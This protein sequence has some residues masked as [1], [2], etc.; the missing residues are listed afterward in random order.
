[1][2]SGPA[3]RYSSPGVGG[4][5]RRLAGGLRFSSYLLGL[6]LWTG[7]GLLYGQG[8]P[9]ITSI[10]P[11]TVT[12]G[13]PT[14]TMTVTGSGY[15][16]S[17]VVRLNG[18][19]RPTIYKSSLQL[20][21]TIFAS[22]LVTATTLQV[23]VF[24]P[25][26]T[27]VG[28]FTSNSVPLTVSTLPPP[29]LTSSAP[30][31]VVQAASRIRLTLVGANFRPGATVV[32]SP[33]VPAVM[34]SN[35]HTRAS[36]IAILSAAVVN[37]NLI[38]AVIS[39]S[40]AATLG[41]RAVDVLNLDGTSTAGSIVN[42]APG[43]SQAMRVEAS[44]S[45]AAPLSVLNIALTQPRDG[46]VVGQGQELNASAILAGTG[47]G[48]V[49]G[50]WV[51]DGNVVEQFSASIVG[52]QS[53][54]IRTRQSLPTWFL[55]THTLQLRM[56]Q[57]NQLATRQVV[58][59]VTPAGWQLQQ[60]ILPSYGAA[61][62]ADHPPELL[63]APV[64]GAAKYQVGFS[65]QPY[66]STVQ[67]WFDVVDNRWEIPPQVWKNLSEG[68]LY[69]TVRAVE[70]S[71][72]AD[73]PLALRTIYRAATG[74]LNP[75][76]PAPSRTPAGNTLLEWQPAVPFGYYFA[77]ISADPA[78]LE[79]IRQYLTSNPRVDLRAA[80]NHLTPGTT[81][82]WQVV[83]L[84]PNGNPLL[85]GP[86]QSFVAQNVP[87]ASLSDSSRLVQLASLGMPAS[88]P[89][90]PAPDLA[91]QIAG[92]TPAPNS[93]VNQLQPAIS[94]SFLS[95]VNPT[96]IS[97]MIDV[98]DVTSLAQVSEVKIAFTPP[99]ALA[100][101]DHIVNL[102]LGS[103]VVT[104]KFTEAAAEP[105][106]ASNPAQPAFQPG[107]DAEAPPAAGNLPTP[108]SM[109]AAHAVKP[110]TTGANVSANP[111]PSEE[112]QISSSTQWASGEN[113]PDT[114]GFSV[115][116]R[117]KWQQGRWRFEE[118]GS[119]LL[120]TIFF[121]ELQRTSQAR[122]NNYIFQLGYKG[123]HWGANLRFGIVSPVLYT[124]A[125]FVTAATPRQGAEVTLTT[126]AGTFAYYANTNDEAL[127]GGQGINFHQQM[128]GA[129][130]QAPLPKWAVFR[131]MW[132]SAQDIGAPTAV[133]FD[134]QGN[135]IVTQNPVATAAKGDVYGA[136]LNIHLR[137]KWLWSSEYAFSRQNADTND[138]TSRSDFGRAWR[139]GI[140]GDTG[141]TNVNLTYRDVG[142]NFGNPANPS[143]TQSSQP[144][145]RG[146][147]SA[148][149][150]TTR[151]GTF[152]LEYTF[153]ENNVQPT[154]ADELLMNS[155]NETWSKPFGVKTN[156]VVGARQSLTNT[157]TVPV[158]L[159]G[160]PAEQSGAADQRD[161]SGNI[162]LTRQI[163]T[164]SMSAGGTR[165]WSRDNLTP[166][167]DT[168]TSSLNFGT[169]L[170]TKGIFQLNSQANVNWVAADGLTVGTN[171]NITVYVQPA[172]LWK[173]PAVQLSPLVT[174]TKGRTILANGQLTSNS[175][176]GQ[177]GGRITWTMPGALK[178]STFAA[179]GTYNQNKDTV[180]S[181]NQPSTQLLVVW[182]VTWGHK[183]T[184]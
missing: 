170:A 94:A 86:P 42:G 2:R 150:E 152:G 70:A 82:Y 63:W 47:T 15:A 151:A 51:W 11:S 137:K 118:N 80:D 32:I 26:F 7:S 183:H 134:A 143:L 12:V 172:F 84:L 58:V 142:P 79:V 25:A 92:R 54:T 126:L 182:T 3:S 113:P 18:S 31:L 19:N 147:D 158:S 71:G 41:L 78:G 160:Q 40:P 168:I 65:T 101:G 81:Y 178:F 144:D 52:G 120:N 75:L 122:I 99:L 67:S 119:G 141:K 135:P 148:V 69:W 64:P 6:L 24:T 59:A 149:S 108:V 61:Y 130:W 57:P 139:T 10:N 39:L 90:N 181:V 89:A 56:V 102:G 21:A 93:T 9:I 4:S 132:L 184:F 173:K 37:S 34:D 5:R 100:G 1:M 176:T 28:G 145:L 29:T 35:G 17:S 76:H 162:S 87:K 72:Q 167:N 36:D 157:G 161:V 88:L 179:Q 109:A 13:G 14:F 124:D 85:S 49:I 146:V 164:L 116:E 166:G 128:M 153:L 180:M 115:A 27:F 123:N 154:T 111:R 97:L 177:Y 74:A 110:G 20:T 174:L 155:F 171:R 77:T 112:G 156:L 95:A 53:T 165:D 107:T 83:A 48:A 66:L 98:V 105:V 30:G 129:S 125:Q 50:Q 121:P 175:L 133:S 169:N 103:E 62:T 45:F 46:T 38:T 140:S 114:N 60:L 8:G 159:E 138:P 106:T 117:F 55:G 33:P 131:L 163:G 68:Q 16:T 136:L 73:K 91:A 96:D 104:W 22:D 43:T 127:G 23:T 44:D